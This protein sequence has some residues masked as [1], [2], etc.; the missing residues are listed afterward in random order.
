MGCVFIY[1]NSKKHSLSLVDAELI[2]ATQSFNNLIIKN[3]SDN[4]IKFL[5]LI[6]KNFS[7]KISKTNLLNDSRHY[8]ELIMKYQLDEDINLAFLKQTPVFSEVTI[9]AKPTRLSIIPLL[10]KT[11]SQSVLVSTKPIADIYEIL[12]LNLKL[13]LMVFFLLFII[14]FPVNRVILNSNKKYWMNR[15][16]DTNTDSVTGLPNQH[17]LII[18]LANTTAPN[19]AFIKILNYNSFINQY[20]PAISENIT[21]QFATVLGGFEDSR[22]VK[23]NIYRIQQSTFAI[24]EDQDNSLAEIID[25]TSKIIKSLLTFDFMVGENEFIKVKVTVG[26]VKQKKDAYT[27]TNMALSE[28]IEKQLPYYFID[29]GEQHLPASYKR[30]LETIKKIRLAINEDRLVPFFQPIFNAKTLQVVKYESLARIVDENN[31]PIILPNIFLPLVNREKLT[32]KIIRIILKKSISFATKNNVKV[33]INLGVHDINNEKTCEYI[34]ASIKNSKINHLLQFELLE[35]EA[36]VD[37]ESVLVFIK[38]IQKLGCKIGIDDLGKGYSNF[39]RLINLPVDFVKI[40]RC[41]MEHIA[42]NL[43]IQNLTK[44]II[45]LAHKNKLKVT[46][47][48][49]T[50]KTITDIAIMLGVDTLQGHYFAEASPDIYTP[51][52]ALK[53]RTMNSQ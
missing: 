52:I 24:L 3:H 36:I 10:T 15:I 30:D 44:G 51:S 43:E 21:K 32:Y 18:D 40:D 2:A 20:G 4:P 23:T 34:Y 26:A 13:L 12:K 41:F 11:D 29:N 49:C 6:E 8:Q 14:L 9:N 50:N 35:N 39:E 47:E 28:A 25:I 16:K 1:Q 5:Y 27:L 33:S 53:K 31:L 19:L 17:Q 7:G 46:A 45:R 48:Y 22:L 37:S 42:D 38:H